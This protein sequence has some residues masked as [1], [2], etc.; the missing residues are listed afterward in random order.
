MKYID[1]GHYKISQVEAIRLAEG[2]LPAAG[3]EKLVYVDGEHYWLGRTKVN[4]KMVWAVREAGRCRLS[5]A[6]KQPPTSR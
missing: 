3:K 6:D 5:L 1:N 4:G 2:S